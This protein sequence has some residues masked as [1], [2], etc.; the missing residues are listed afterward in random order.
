M[1]VFGKEH[2]LANY[3]IFETDTFLK[4]VTM[5]DTGISKTLVSKLAKTV[6]PQLRE[7]PV[8][9]PNIRKLQNYTPDTWRYRMG[10]YRLFYEVD[11]TDKMVIILYIEHRQNAY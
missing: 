4:A 1:P 5:L 6:Y 11:D 7:N 2:S 9:G 8:Y 3:Q 10:N